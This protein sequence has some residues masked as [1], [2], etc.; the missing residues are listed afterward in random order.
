MAN[1]DLYAEVMERWRR[2]DAAE[3]LAYA[4]VLKWGPFSSGPTCECDPDG[5]LEPRAHNDQC[6]VKMLE[7]AIG[8]IIQGRQQSRE[9]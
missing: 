5:A 2:E 3:R 4:V 1:D 9:K 7:L 8:A 6:P